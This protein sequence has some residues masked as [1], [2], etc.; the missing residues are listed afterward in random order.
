MNLLFP[1]FH[2][3]IGLVYLR[4]QSP[5]ETFPEI[6]ITDERQHTQGELQPHLTVAVSQTELLLSGSQGHNWGPATLASSIPGL[7][8]LSATDW[9]SPTL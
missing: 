8:D 3:C 2:S 1:F 7:P 5:S 6:T 9:D 4:Q